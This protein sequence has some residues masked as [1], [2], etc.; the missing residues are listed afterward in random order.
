MAASLR[1]AGAMGRVLL[2]SIFS[3]LVLLR[4]LGLS[5]AG[6]FHSRSHELV[7][8][9]AVEGGHPLFHCGWRL[10]R[11]EFLVEGRAGSDD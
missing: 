5:G 9:K 1:V 7:R 2:E 6:S 11:L 10:H 3:T 4:L 8:G